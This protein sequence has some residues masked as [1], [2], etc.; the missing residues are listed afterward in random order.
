MGKTCFLTTI[1]EYKSTL[2]TEWFLSLS[3]HNRTCIMLTFETSHEY[4]LGGDPCLYYCEEHGSLIATP[5]HQ[6]RLVLSGIN[7]ETML[8]FAKK[9][10]ARDLEKTLAKHED[11]DAEDKEAVEA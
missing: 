9:L 5:D 2:F 8:S 4:Y 6:D 3:F 1:I 10:V 7:K 11:K